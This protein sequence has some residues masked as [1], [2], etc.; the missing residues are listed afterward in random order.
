LLIPGF[1]RPTTKVLSLLR[2]SSQLLPGSMTGPIIMGV[3]KSDA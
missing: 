2:L 1:S 3:Q